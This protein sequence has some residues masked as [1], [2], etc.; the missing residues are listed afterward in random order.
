MKFNLVHRRNSTAVRHQ[1]ATST[2]LWQRKQA[3]RCDS[4]VYIS[5]TA[6]ATDG[7][8]T[9]VAAAAL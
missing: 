4:D 9:V 3:Q 1:C 7:A 2:T 8:V 6:M 5:V